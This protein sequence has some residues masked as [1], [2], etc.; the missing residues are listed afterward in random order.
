MI[1]AYIAGA[2]FLSGLSVGVL[3]YL[4]AA[5]TLEQ[6]TSVRLTALVDARAGALTDYLETIRQDLVIQAESPFVRDALND[7]SEGWAELGGDAGARLQKTFIDSNP[8]PTGEKDKLVDPKDGTVYGA[9][10]AAHHPWFWRL[11]RDRGY[12]DVFLVNRQGDLVYTVFKELDYATNLLTGKYKDTGLGKVVQLAL[13]ASSGDAVAFDDFKPYSPSHGAPASFI[14]APIMAGGKAVGALVFQMPIGRIN[15]TMNVATGLGETG[16]TMIVGADQLMRSDSRFSQESTILARKIE[17]NAVN[18]ALSGGKGIADGVDAKGQP[19]LDAYAGTSFLGT[20]WAIVAA[21]TKDEVIAPARSLLVWTVLTVVAVVILL[22][23]GGVLVARGITVP[24]RKLTDVMGLLAGGDLSVSIT[25][26]DRRDEIGGM[27]RSVDYFKRKLVE[28]ES[29]QR[30]QAEAASREQAR[31]ERLNGLSAQFDRAVNDVIARVTDSTDALLTSATA[32]RSQADESQ[33][34]AT[35]VASAAEESAASV[36]SAAASG[37]QLSASIGEIARQVGDTAQIAREAVSQATTTNVSIQ[38]LSAAAAKVSEVMELIG[39]I[40]SQTNLLALNAT[41][42]AARAGDAGKG[43][44]VVASEVKALANQ[45]AGATEEIAAQIEAMQAETRGA[46]EA[47]EAITG[48]IERISEISGSVSAAVEEQSAATQEIARAINDVS[49][50]TQ[51]VTSNILAVDT[52]TK[53]TGQ[54]ASEVA[55]A[56]AALQV[57]FK[58][59]TGQVSDFLEDMKAA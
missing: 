47:I 48:T 33:S 20:D 1:P 7:F 59:L 6:E 46:V 13:K 32:M 3:T 53:A 45:T 37:D 23:I 24:I 49:S 42:E 19:T 35:L 9:R 38:G 8:N 22:I 28:N 58:T 29:L 4:Q 14:A 5:D 56:V 44:A 25:A 15:A 57:E 10:H 31:A 52:A 41:I 11:Q 16:E 43:F 2:A 51:E 36:Q 27:A 34:R 40:A 12:Y 17:S 54:T 26:L 30:E 55:S 39:Q 21:I 18:A 50:G